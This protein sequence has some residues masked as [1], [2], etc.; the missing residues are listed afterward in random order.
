MNGRLSER[1]M[2]A[3][4]EGRRDELVG[5]VLTVRRTSAKGIQV[6]I[7]DEDG[8]VLTYLPTQQIDVGSKLTVVHLHMLFDITVST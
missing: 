1:F 4:L 2:K 8:E 6:C 7:E 3:L 5:K